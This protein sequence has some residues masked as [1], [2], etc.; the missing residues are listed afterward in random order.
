MTNEGFPTSL[1][2]ACG[3]CRPPSVGPGRARELLS[4][5]VEASNEVV[6]PGE[7]VP[8]YLL[9]PPY[10]PDLNIEGNPVPVTQPTRLS[11]LLQ[12]N[13]GVCNWTACRQVFG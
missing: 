5:L 13:M 12:P 9:A 7:S 3:Q 4:S 6:G 10:S 11:E 2:A 8:G 1:G